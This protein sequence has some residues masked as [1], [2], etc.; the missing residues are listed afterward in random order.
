MLRE[1][2]SH[3]CQEPNKAYEHKHDERVLQSQELAISESLTV[4]MVS[5]SETEAVKAWPKKGHNQ[6]AVKKKSRCFNENNGKNPKQIKSH[7]KRLL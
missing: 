5:K 3:M 6:M 4:K 7:R 1:T 2:P